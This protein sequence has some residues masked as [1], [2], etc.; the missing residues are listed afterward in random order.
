MLVYYYLE[1]VALSDSSKSTQDY[2]WGHDNKVSLFPGQPVQFV[3]AA[4]LC[5]NCVLM[6][7][8]QSMSMAK[9]VIYGIYITT[10]SVKL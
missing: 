3:R 4:V 1:P 5:C 9:R 7:Q 6:F 10:I 8:E 2:Y